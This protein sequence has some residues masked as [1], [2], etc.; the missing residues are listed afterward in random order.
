MKIIAFVR[1]Y[2]SKHKGKLSLYVIL[3]FLLWATSL[4]IPYSVGAYLDN[5]LLNKNHAV[6][7]NTVLSLAVFWTLQILLSYIKNMVCEVVHSRI[8]NE[9]RTELLEHIINLPVK[10]L[11]KTNHAY[12]A[13]RIHSDSTEIVGF[14]L[15]HLLHVFTSVLSVIFAGCFVAKLNGGIFLILIVLIPFYILIFIFFKKPLY[16]IKYK[17][18][19]NF[20]QYYSKVDRLLANFKLIKTQEWQPRFFEEIKKSY[21]ILFEST[22]QNAKLGYIF[23]N[24]DAFVRYA[25]NISIFVYSGYQ[26][27]NN[28][29]SVGQFTM[30]NSYSMMLISCMS[31]LLH[32]GKVYRQT[33]VAYDRI[34]AIYQEKEEVCGTICVDSISEISTENLSFS[35]GDNEVLKD[36]SISLIKGNIYAVVGENGSGKSTL[37]SVLSG[38]EQDYSGTV[39]YDGI[40]LRLLDHHHLKKYVLSITEQ[41]PDLIFQTIKMNIS[42]SEQLDENVNHWFEIFNLNDLSLKSEEHMKEQFNGRTL[43]LSGGEKQKIAIIRSLVKNTDVLIFDEPNSAFDDEGTQLLCKILQDIKDTH[44]IIIVT[45]RPELIGISDVVIQL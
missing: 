22:I 24:V 8:S 11:G 20:S 14:V 7:W 1:P 28:K 43:K 39:R 32:F 23:S 30:A 12:L 33:M 40:D 10:F 45:H 36:L 5:L 38:L 6:I 44:I 18:A 27:L 31:G 2:L 35:Y 42:D 29:M 25:A 9:I 15:G 21:G 26:I 4:A 41:E 17:H 16:K 3:S 19:E 37:L 34:D 13:Q